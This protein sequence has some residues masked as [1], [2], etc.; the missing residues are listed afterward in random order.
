MVIGL[1]ALACAVLYTGGPFPLAYHGLGDL[2]VFVYFGLVAVAGTYYVQALSFPAEAWWAGAGAGALSTALLVVNNLR[3]RET[4]AR[5]G[6]RTLAVRLGRRGTQVE[7]TLLVALAAAVPAVGMAVF[8]WP[9][10]SGAAWIGLVA[11]LPALK[12]VWR[13]TAPAELLPALAETA[14]ALLVWAVGLSLGLVW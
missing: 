4:D 3:D 9:V 2:F 1:S 7:Y 8:A 5:A 13:F 11:A 12:R 14:R 10:A 6:K